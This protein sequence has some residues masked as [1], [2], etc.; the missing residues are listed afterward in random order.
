VIFRDRVFWP[1]DKTEATAFCGDGGD[2]LTSV[3]IHFYLNG[4][5]LPDN[6]VTDATEE[7]TGVLLEYDGQLFEPCS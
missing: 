3:G 4:K 1:C 5:K 6:T 7:T 2:K